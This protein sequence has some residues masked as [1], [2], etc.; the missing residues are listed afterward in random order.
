MSSL[1]YEEAYNPESRAHHL[2]LFLKSGN[3]NPL[4]HKAREILGGPSVLGADVA[5]R[6]LS[7]A[8]PPPGYTAVTREK[9][10]ADQFNGI[11][12]DH[13]L[14]SA[15]VEPEFEVM[16]RRGEI[17]V[18]FPNGSD[19]RPSSETQR[20]MPYE[21]PYGTTHLFGLKKFEEYFSSRFKDTSVTDEVVKAGKRN[22]LI[23]D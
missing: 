18:Y 12:I 2:K 4:I 15:K 10:P 5:D 21:V 13:I 6:L 14:E 16:R 11:P 7:K 8:T 19:E 17:L 23:R 1:P 20:R 9:L 22:G 3:E